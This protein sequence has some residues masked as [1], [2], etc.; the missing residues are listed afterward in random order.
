[1]KKFALIALAFLI[2]LSLCSCSS[3]LNKVKSYVT[4]N[5]VSVVPEDF[6]ESRSN[7]EYSYDVYK[8]Y[9]EITGYLGEETVIVLPSEL[10]GKPVTSVGSLAF[11]EKAKVTSVT[12]PDSVTNIAESAF[13]YADSLVSVVLPDTVTSIGSRAFAWCDSLTAV[14]IG[15][16]VGSIPDFCFNHCS[17]LVTVSVPTSVKNIGVRAFSYCDSLADIT[18]PYSVEYL[19]DMCFANC[20]ALEYCDL[21]NNAITFGANVFENSSEVTLISQL[22]STARDY[23]A[24]HGMRWSQSRFIEAIIPSDGVTA[25]ESLEVSAE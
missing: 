17:S 20:P 2:C 25:D 9:I 3:I 4:G 16:G 11:F 24:E 12:I 14:H 19:G 10:D 6:L 1:M 7:D 5:E 8:E 22:S 23:C 18:L 15:S 21:R 13:Y